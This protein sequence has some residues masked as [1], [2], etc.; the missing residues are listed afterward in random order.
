MLL[1]IIFSLK[2]NFQQQNWNTF[3]R[4]LFLSAISLLDLKCLTGP[5]RRVLQSH[6]YTIK[7]IQGTTLEKLLH[8]Y[9]RFNFTLNIYCEDIIMKTDLND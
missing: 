3:Q 1:Y 6:V 5:S 7:S 9:H 2:H 4:T 8:V